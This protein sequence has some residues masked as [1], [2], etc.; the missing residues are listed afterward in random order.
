MNLTQLLREIENLR[1]RKLNALGKARFVKVVDVDRVNDRVVLAVGSSG[2]RVS[3]PFSEFEK[4]LNALN[5]QP[6][7]HVDSVLAGSGT[8]RNQPETVLANLPRIEVLYVSGRK[9][10]ARVSEPSHGYGTI[11][12]MDEL[13]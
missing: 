8:S 3:R 5:S 1:G 12:E 4:L 9:H 13:G 6:A 2:T 7:I 11:R 10:L